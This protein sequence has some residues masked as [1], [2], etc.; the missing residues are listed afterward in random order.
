MTRSFLYIL[1]ICTTFLVTLSSFVPANNNGIVQDVLDQTNQ[2]RRSKGLPALMMR[3]DLNSIAQKHSADMASGRT[4]FGHDGFA[5]RNAQA[6]RT[7]RLMH[8]FGENVAYGVNSGKAVV[9]MWKDS[10]GHRRNLLGQFKYIGIGIAKD[11]KGRIYYTQVFA[12]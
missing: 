8:R 7:I 9:K 12:G 11:K 3:S 10:P 1:F 4:A 2:F 6:T 5:Q